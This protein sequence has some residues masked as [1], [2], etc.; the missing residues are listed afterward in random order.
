MRSQVPLTDAD[1]LQYRDQHGSPLAFVLEPSHERFVVGR[2]SQC[3]LVIAWDATV[4][5]A[6]ATIE[7]VATWW[8]LADSG[9]SRN[10]TFVG[11]ERLAG[12]RRLEHGVTIRIGDT[13]LTYRRGRPAEA[14]T[15]S[16]DP[17][18]HTTDAERRVLTALCAPL[19]TDAHAL[20]ATNHEIA[21][22]L[23]LSEDRVKELMG[24]LFRKLRVQDLRPGAKRHTLAQRAR[25]LG[26]V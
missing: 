11:G 22:T 18:P 4:S 6:H 19:M 16:S 3:D 1:V 20:P 17:V 7:R 14:S 15:R 5:R 9:L 10:G 26:L 8:V 13:V 25:E 24:D 23:F 2:S 12:G 21:S